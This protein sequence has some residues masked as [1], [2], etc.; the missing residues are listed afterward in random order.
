M[1]KCTKC[2][3]EKPVDAFSLN[4]RRKDGRQEWCKVCLSEHHLANRESIL[5]KHAQYREANRLKLRLKQA[6]YNALHASKTR[7][8]SRDWRAKVKSDP[9][10]FER[11]REQTNAGVKRSR[12]K[13]PEREKARLA[14]SNA[15]ISGKMTRPSSCSSCGCECKPEAHHDSYDQDQWFNVRWLCRPCHEIHHR[16]YPEQKTENKLTIT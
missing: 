3:T 14:V 4:K 1:K 11:Y 16:K 8:Y 7:I 2:K 9:I 6:E 12:Q 5:K 15:I 10:K 13:Y